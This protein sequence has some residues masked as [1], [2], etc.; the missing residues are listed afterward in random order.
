MD[1]YPPLAGVGNGNRKVTERGEILT[2]SL[3][4]SLKNGNCLSYSRKEG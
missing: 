1:G 4:R 2:I 3:L